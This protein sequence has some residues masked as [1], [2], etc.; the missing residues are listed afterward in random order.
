MYNLVLAL[1][2]LVSLQVNTLQA[3]DLW[4]CGSP[5]L[6]ME[7]NVLLMQACKEGEGT[8][9]GETIPRMRPPLSL[10]KEKGNPCLLGMP[11]LSSKM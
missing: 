11:T 7:T 4:V 1:E 9:G 10:S 2:W 5:D 8:M 6:R 3:L